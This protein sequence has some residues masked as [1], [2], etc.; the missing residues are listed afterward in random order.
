MDIKDYLSNCSLCPR[1]CNVNRLNNEMGFCNSGKELSVARASLHYWEE[2][3]LSGESGSGTVFF[4]GCSLGCCYCQNNAIN[5]NEKKYTISSKRLSEIFFDLKN[6]GANNINLVTA[7][8]YLPH[9]INAIDVSRSKGLN[10]PIVYNSSGYDNGDTIK[11]LKGKI[12]I[13]L[14]DFKYYSDEIAKRYSNAPDYVKYAK[15]SLDEMVAQC[16]KPTF[17]SNGIMQKGV[18]VRHLV[19]P[20]QV[21]DS[22]RIIDYLFNRYGN[23]IYISIMNQY[24]PVDCLNHLKFPELSRKV[25]ADEYNEV[26][27]FAIDLGVENGFIQEGET[28]EESFI[29]SFNGEG[30]L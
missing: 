4:T 8:H 10:I 17:N 2:P 19:L 7:T 30:V 13:Y 26:V 11:M 12:D 27:D 29:P 22:K 24:T 28:A 3:C 21:E 15:E 1:K 9:I 6:K 14:P 23:S 20:G 16:P 18:I 25:T 5:R